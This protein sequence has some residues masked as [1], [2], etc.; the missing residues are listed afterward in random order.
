MRRG[1]KERLKTTMQCIDASYFYVTYPEVIQFGTC[2]H[3]TKFTYLTQVTRSFEDL[4]NCPQKTDL[5]I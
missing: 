5:E 4:Q 2:V 3:F 1:E